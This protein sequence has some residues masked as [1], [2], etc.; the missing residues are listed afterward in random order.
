MSK[1]TVAP[2]TATAVFN[3]AA[4]MPEFSINSLSSEAHYSVRIVR[5]CVWDWIAAGRCEE[6]EGK[7]SKNRTL[8]RLKPIAGKADKPHVKPAQT[9]LGNMWFAMQQLKT[10][11]AVDVAA[12]A[13][14]EEMDV[15]PIDAQAYCSSLVKG[16]TP[17]LRV[18]RKAAPGKHPAIYKLIRNTGPKPP[19]VKR[20]S[21]VFD[22]NLNDLT[23]I[24]PVRL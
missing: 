18:H 20:V 16:D 15:Q 23:Y 4:R 10:F 17:H 22:P 3:A 6:L 19:Q 7:G 24:A 8:Y 14:T 5:L 12:S 11:T 1:Q 9:K 13:W 2:E 21:A